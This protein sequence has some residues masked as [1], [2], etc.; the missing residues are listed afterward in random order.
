MLLPKRAIS[1]IIGVFVF[2]SVISLTSNIVNSR[3]NPLYWLALTMATQQEV[4]TPLTTHIVLLQFKAGASSTAVKEVG[5]IGTHN[6]I[7]ST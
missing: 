1:A 4:Q 2:L 5:S 3:L 7:M 6:M